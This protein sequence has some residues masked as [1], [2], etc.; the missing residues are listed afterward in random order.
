[1]R[2]WFLFLLVMLVPATAAAQQTYYVAPGGRATAAGTLADP[3][4]GIPTALAHV[5][6]GDTIYVRGGT[7]VSPVPIRIDR[8]GLEG[9]Y[10]HIWAYP[11]ETPVFDFT[12]ASRGF[13][14]RGFYLHLKGLVAEHA[15]DNGFYLKGASYNILEQVVAR[16]N[17]DSGVQLEDGASY[18]LLLNVDSYG[19]YDPGNHGENAD[20]FAI[21]FG[22]GPGNVLRGC[23]A[24]GNSDDGYDFWS[25][26]DPGQQGVTVEDSWA[27]KNGI[28]V[29][30]DPGFQGDSNGFKLGHG[31]GPHVLTG[32]V[33]WGHR[34]HG[35][36]VNGN[37]SGVTLYNNTAYLNGGYDF[38]FDDDPNVADG[39]HVLRNNLAYG[40]VRM[41]ATVVDDAGNAW[42]AGLPA[43][44]PSFFLSLDDTGADGPRGPDGSLPV[45]PFLRLAAGSPY[46]DAGVDVGRPYEGAAPDLGAF[47]S[48]YATGTP[49]Q[50]SNEVPE[51]LWLGAP[52]P[53]PFVDRVHLTFEA[54]PAE[55][56]RLRIF[57]VLGRTVTTLVDGA[58]APGR[59]TV[60]WAA[61]AHLPPGLYFA[62]LEAGGSVQVVRLVKAR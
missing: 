55:E 1:M 32:N 19:N 39:G 48:P 10:L 23:R 12:G 40:R 6:P 45:L 9:Q 22:V 57:D 13:D 46:I 59:H 7:Y 49:V 14:L 11:G 8:T 41:D 47:E 3:F 21:K 60:T 20:G 25:R 44:Q 36:D 35:F 34:A 38:Y 5:S 58:V 26:D 2:G 27:F 28:N 16:Y 18:N 52:Y 33:A 4:D 24:W 51:R 37:L 61:G 42:N 43:P 50:V 31:P 56:Y 29:W 17:G 53:N 54:A 62:R 15:E 30:D